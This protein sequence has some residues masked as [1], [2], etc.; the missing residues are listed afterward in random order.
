M[1][2]P[3][4]AQI[5]AAEGSVHPAGCDIL[6][7]GRALGIGRHL[8]GRFRH[9]DC[10]AFESV[11]SNDA[12]DLR[13]GLD[14]GHPR[15]GQARPAAINAPATPAPTISTSLCSAKRLSSD[16]GR[17]EAQLSGPPRHRPGEG[18]TPATRHIKVVSKLR[19]SDNPSRLK[20]GIPSVE[21]SL[22]KRCAAIGVRLERGRTRRRD[23]GAQEQLHARSRSVGWKIS[24]AGRSPGPRRN[25]ACNASGVDVWHSSSHWREA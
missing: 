3:H 6:N 14:H 5:S 1:V 4:Q 18:S 11:Q 19:T 25:R 20:S 13:A 22:L 2:P 8:A 23:A 21:Q 10:R 9:P 7:G 24:E 12:V 15:A 16:I 17:A